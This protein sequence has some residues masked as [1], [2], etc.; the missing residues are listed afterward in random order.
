M[1]IPGAFSSLILQN[2]E[3]LAIILLKIFLHFQVLYELSSSE[4][5]GPERYYGAW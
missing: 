4:E 2:T 1:K 3:M 5:W